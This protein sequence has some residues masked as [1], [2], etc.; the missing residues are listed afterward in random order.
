MFSQTG[1]AK[2]S[3]GDML[4]RVFGKG[5]REAHAGKDRPLRPED[6]PVPGVVSEYDPFASLDK[7]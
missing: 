6:L 5:I 7:E 3:F 4:E 1:T 2:E